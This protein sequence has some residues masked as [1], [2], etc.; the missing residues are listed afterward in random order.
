MTVIMSAT[1]LPSVRA[2]AQQTVETL[3]SYLAA[4]GQ[5]DYLGEAVSQLEHSLQC[6]DLAVKGG[7][8]DDTVLAALLHDVGRFIPR[9]D[10]D[11]LP[12]MLAPDGTFLGKGSHEVTGEKFLRDIGF[13]TKVCELVGS[14]VWAKRYLS[15]VE[16]GYYDRLSPTSKV[17]LKYQVRS[18]SQYVVHG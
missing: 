14:H 4:Q 13:S 16:S 3:F 11:Q 10:Y 15:A 12:S 5:G 18:S 7:A 2:H 17:T 6:A 8:D 1:A 9:S